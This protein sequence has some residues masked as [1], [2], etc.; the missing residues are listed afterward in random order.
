MTLNY[1]FCKANQLVANPN[2]TL[3]EL[4]L[5]DFKLVLLPYKLNAK[6]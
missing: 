5:L 6:L 1:C 3:L 4:K 2:L